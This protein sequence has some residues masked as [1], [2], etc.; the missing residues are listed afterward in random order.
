MKTVWN[1]AMLLLAIFIG[2]NEEGLWN[3]ITFVPL[4][5]LTF[6]YSKP[7]NP[8]DVYKTQSY[9]KPN[10]YSVL[11]DHDGWVEIE[12]YAPVQFDGPWVHFTD[13]ITDFGYH[14]KRSFYRPIEIRE[15][16]PGS[17]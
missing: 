3:L 12:C 17:D 11:T 8:E 14:P 15:I 1:I 7:N 6:W 10:R 13:E 4:I 9:K 5:F 16:V 2:A